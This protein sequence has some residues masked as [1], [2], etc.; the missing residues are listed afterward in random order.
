MKLAAGVRGTVGCDGAAF[1]F[2]Y[3]KSKHSLLFENFM[4]ACLT[5]NMFCSWLPFLA[6]TVCS[7]GW[8]G[9]HSQGSACLCFRSAGMKGLSSFLKHIKVTLGQ[10][11]GK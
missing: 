2:H 11:Y 7:P 1:V 3:T 6:E 9:S 8:P 4:L 10:V 5:C